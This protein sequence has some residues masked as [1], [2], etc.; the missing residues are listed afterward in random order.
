VMNGAGKMVM[1][2]VIEPKAS[3]I[4]QFIDGLRGG[5]H[6]WTGYRKTKGGP[7]EPPLESAVL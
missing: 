7:E 1:G 5:A 6:S 2:C 4:L 3:M